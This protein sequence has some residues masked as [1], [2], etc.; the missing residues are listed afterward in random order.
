[1]DKEKLSQLQEE[2]ARK[3]RIP[4]NEPFKIRKQN[5]IFSFDIQYEGNKGYVAIDIQS[6]N[7]TH[8]GTFVG[9]YPVTMEYQPGYFAFR[10]GPLL[11]KALEDV[12][13]QK[14]FQPTV[15]IIDGHGQAH[16]RKM[17]IATWLGIETGIPSIGVAKEPLLKT[18]YKTILENDAGATVDVLLNNELVGYVLRSQTDVK[19]IF[20]SAGHLISQN[21]SL[22]IIKKLRGPYRVIESIRRADKIAREA[23]DGKISLSLGQ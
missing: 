23:A 5:L 15:L 22:R 3:V 17:G 2:M 13:R 18:E 8:Q 21:E 19:P 16:P 14:G 20:V 10:E 9:L 4:Q 11:K 12:I 6:Y 7:G 1:M